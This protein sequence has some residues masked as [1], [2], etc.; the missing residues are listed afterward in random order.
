MTQDH[1]AL[2]AQARTGIQTKEMLVSGGET[3]DL[4]ATFNLQMKLADALEA[5]AAEIARLREALKKIAEYKPGSSSAGMSP[6]DAQAALQGK[7][8]E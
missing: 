4:V 3:V 6:W 2:V 8:G 1:T 5:Q 7:A